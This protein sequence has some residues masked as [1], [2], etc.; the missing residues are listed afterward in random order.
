MDHGR[1]FSLPDPPE[2]RSARF[3]GITLD[4][5]ARVI[6]VAD[7]QHVGSFRELELKA[8]AGVP[9]LVART[10]TAN[11]IYRFDGSPP[12]G[13]PR[14]ATEEVPVQLI[15]RAVQAGWPEFD[16]T[17]VERPGDRDPYG[18]LRAGTLPPTTLRIKLNDAAATW[19]Q[20]DASSGSILS[21]MDR[22]RRI[23]RWL[24]NG[25]H[26]FDFPILARHRPLWDIVILCA[27]LAGFAFSV[28]AVVIA[29]RR[30]GWTLRG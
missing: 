18:Q 15:Q 26:H 4:E 30:A 6:R 2:L 3:Q 20:V 27:L 17:A 19:I 14:E 16:I 11:R 13:S 28:T 8:I 21:V 5:A 22:S 25:L 10:A 7:L 29:I 23:Y 24:Y 9:L 12:D 1:I